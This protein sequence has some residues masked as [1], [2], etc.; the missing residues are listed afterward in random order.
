M[1]NVRLLITVV[2]SVLLLLQGILQEILLAISLIL[3]VQVAGCD[4]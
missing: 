3:S 4:I 1:R 2:R